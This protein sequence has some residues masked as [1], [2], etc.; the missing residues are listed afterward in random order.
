MSAKA[1]CDARFFYLFCLEFSVTNVRLGKG[2]ETMDAAQFTDA[3]KVL[4]L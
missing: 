2:V 1:C 3:Q 4:E